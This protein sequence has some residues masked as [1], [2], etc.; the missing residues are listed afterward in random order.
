MR[1]IIN[2]PFFSKIKKVLLV[3]ILIKIEHKYRNAQHGWKNLKT[4]HK[5]TAES[6]FRNLTVTFN[7]YTGIKKP[8]MTDTDKFY[9]VYSPKKF[10]LKPKDDIYLDL[11]F[12]VETSQEL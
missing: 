8:E 1:N 11:Q 9:K 5:K 12:N 7:S 3:F 2:I 10:K 4:R 6:Y